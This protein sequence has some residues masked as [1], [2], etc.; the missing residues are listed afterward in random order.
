MD[1]APLPATYALAAS[2]TSFVGREW[3]PAEVRPLLC[4]ARLVTLTG[5]GGVGKPRLLSISASGW[6]APLALELAATWVRAMSCHQ[7]APRD[8]PGLDLLSTD[9]PLR[10]LPERHHSMR[11]VF[12]QSS[13]L[14]SMQEQRTMTQLSVF[15]GGFDLQAAEEVVWPHWSCW[16]PGG[17]VAGTNKYRPVRTNTGR[18]DLHALVRQYM[19]EKLAESGHATLPN[20][21]PFP[22][23]RAI[24]GTGG[25]SPV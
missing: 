20:R 16:P 8:R 3:E 10:N 21:L 22:L 24:S 19:S 9:V 25:G 18:Y 1:A 6:K 17:Q 5:T 14:L 2:L 7:I 11:I 23:L 4:T 13:I 15:R 12:D